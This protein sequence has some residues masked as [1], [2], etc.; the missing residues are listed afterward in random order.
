MFGYVTPLKSEL[1]IKDYVK[2]RSYYC[3]LCMSFKKNI[4]NLPRLTLNYDMAFLAVLLDS[5]SEKE[6][7]IEIKRCLPHPLEKKPIIVNNDAIDYAAAMNLSLYYFKVKDDIQDDN[8]LKSKLL[9]KVLY[10][11]EKKLNK[12]LRKISSIIEKNLNELANFEKNKNF[13]NI[14][15]ISHPF[16]NIV[17]NILKEY[18]YPLIDDSEILRNN[19]YNLGYTLG[20]WIYLIDAVDDLKEDIENKKFNPI[21]FLF[22]QDSKP[23][24]ELLNSIK[25]RLEFTILNCAYNCKEILSKLPLKRNSD[26]LKNILELGIMD[27]YLSVINKRCESKRRK[28]NESI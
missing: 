26:I 24:E 15:E 21:I 18:P 12:S 17:G 9:E 7:S 14:D 6:A 4:G 28:R 27:K 8:K 20:K 1:K 25:D 23:Y 11:Y 19:L 22:N 2:F 13:S 5:I 16:S 10:P 3:G